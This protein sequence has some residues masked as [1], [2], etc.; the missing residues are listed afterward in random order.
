MNQFPGFGM[1]F[2]DSPRLRGYLGASRLQGKLFHNK[3]KYKG[4]PF[5]LRSAW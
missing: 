4:G 2:A 3:S 1:N 5:S